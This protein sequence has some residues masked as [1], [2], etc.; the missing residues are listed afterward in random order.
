MCIH[1]TR[2]LYECAGNIAARGVALDIAIDAKSKES[3]QVRRIN[4]IERVNKK[5]LIPSEYSYVARILQAV[6][7]C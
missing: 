1:A 7:Y 3:Q 6:L 4:A 5:V 2:K